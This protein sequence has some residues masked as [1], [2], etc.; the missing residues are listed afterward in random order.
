MAIERDVSDAALD[1][2]SAEDASSALRA[3]SNIADPPSSADQQNRRQM[4][5][6][7]RARLDASS[8]SDNLIKPLEDPSTSTTVE[9]GAFTFFEAKIGG[10]AVS[11]WNSS[12]TVPRQDGIDLGIIGFTHSSDRPNPRLLELAVENAKLGSNLQSGLISKEA[13]PFLPVTGKYLN[14]GVSLETAKLL[15]ADQANSNKPSVDISAKSNL[16]GGDLPVEDL[17][18]S[19]AIDPNAK[20]DLTVKPE[21]RF[22][23]NPSEYNVLDPRRNLPSNWNADGKA[24]YLLNAIGDRVER[25]TTADQYVGEDR[26]L[27]ATTKIRS[28]SGDM[29]TKVT[30]SNPDEIDNV[31]LLFLSLQTVDRKDFPQAIVDVANQFKFNADCM[32]ALQLAQKEENSELSRATQLAIVEKQLQQ[33]GLKYYDIALEQAKAI[34]GETK[35]QSLL[36]AKQNVEGILKKMRETS[37]PD[38][39]NDFS[40]PMAVSV[41]QGKGL[42]DAE[43]AAAGKLYASLFTRDEF[44]RCVGRAKYNTW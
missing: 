35:E 42:T 36:E 14:Q 41:E 18:K 38:L 44:L 3:D 8:L 32:H 40:A 25:D 5:A 9:R 10:D 34:K 7:D 28:R 19:I 37:S 4:S 27:V 6:A 21:N 11:K 13:Q 33:Y 1:S 24:D 43:K 17:S 16:S 20:P 30:H 26:N 23:A 31:K 39:A 15:G 22:S 2:K 12:S 29:N